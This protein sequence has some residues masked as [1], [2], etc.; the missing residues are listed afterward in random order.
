MEFTPENT[1]TKVRNHFLIAMKYV[2]GKFF[3]DLL[4]LIPFNFISMLKDV[5]NKEDLKFFF[6]IKI[7]RLKQGDLIFNERQIKSYVKQLLA[8]RLTN[9]IKNKPHLA[10]DQL[11]DNS[12]I[13][14]LIII[15]HVI[16]IVKMF[17]LIMT[18]SYF[19]GIFWLVFC[20]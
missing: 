10:N 3:V 15:K 4:C 19:V 14:A 13:S 5:E 6:L 7:L 8:K 11:N 2:K 17:I 16:S 1:T 12:K 20:E 9:L 18:L